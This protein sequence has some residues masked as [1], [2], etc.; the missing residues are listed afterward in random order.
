[1]EGE[2]RTNKNDPYQPSPISNVHP[3]VHI[4]E[5]DGARCHCCT[6]FPNTKVVASYR[7]SSGGGVNEVRNEH[8]DGRLIKTVEHEGE[9]DRTIIFRPSDSRS[10]KLRH[11]KG[12]CCRDILVELGDR[13]KIA[14]QPIKLHITEHRHARY[15][16]PRQ[17]ER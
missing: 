10:I 16:G 12:R 2:S 6:E 17:E 1:M 11:R 14:C 13:T 15:R 5:G 7:E 3:D 8:G 9:E 4:G